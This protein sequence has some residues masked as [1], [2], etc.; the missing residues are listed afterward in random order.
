VPGG[1]ANRPMP[2]E[3]PTTNDLINARFEELRQQE[4]RLKVPAAGITDCT[5]L[6][7]PT[8][9]P[10]SLHHSSRSVL[11]CMIEAVLSNPEGT[12]AIINPG[13]PWYPGGGVVVDHFKHQNLP[14][15]ETL[16]LLGEGAFKSLHAG[17]R[18]YPL[19]PGYPCERQLYSS[20]VR[21]RFNRHTLQQLCDVTGSPRQKLE[22]QRD[23]L[24]KAPLAASPGDSPAWHMVTVVAPDNRNS[25]G[26]DGDALYTGMLRQFAHAL[27]NGQKHGVRTYL[28]MLSGSGLFAKTSSEP[29]A[30]AYPPYQQALACAAVDAVRYFGKGMD[31]V[32]PS[33]GEQIDKLI[34]LYE[35]QATVPDAVTSRYQGT[36][37]KPSV[38]MPPLSNPE[39]LRMRRMCG[40]RYGT[41]SKN[42]ALDRNSGVAKALAP[43]I[44]DFRKV[45]IHRVYGVQ[46]PVEGR[47]AY[48]FIR[49]DGDPNADRALVSIMNPDGSRE[50]FE[51]VYSGTALPELAAKAKLAPSR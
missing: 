31:V 5:A 36:P 44:R 46:P 4:I 14:F 38:T 33:H 10:N 30:R 28:L 32:I 47:Q 40:L 8:D 13:D 2:P 42:F 21:F 3:V 9:R 15:E 51:V 18:A 49:H 17:R 37:L 43:L 48:W 50:V 34:H 25:P 1:V 6:P 24:V 19:G 29:D 35:T 22:A 39:E 23:L 11:K 12:V 45:S 7:A 27:V 20:N 16:C 26:F 41:T